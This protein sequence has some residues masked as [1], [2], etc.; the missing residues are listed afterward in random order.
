VLEMTGGVGREE[1]WNTVYA[2]NAD[3]HCETHCKLCV[4]L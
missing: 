3:L 2:N 4:T 1:V